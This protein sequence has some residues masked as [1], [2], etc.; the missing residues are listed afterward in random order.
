MVQVMN[1]FSDKPD[2][3]FSDNII[4]HDLS[5]NPKII[6]LNVG[7]EMKKWRYDS[8]T[9][10][11][12]E[13]LPEFALKYSDLLQ[14]RSATATKFLRKA[15]QTI[16]NTDK[17]GKRGEFGELLLHAIIRE[18]FDSEPVISKIYYKSA[19]NDTVKGF[20]AVHVVE[21]NAELELWLGEVKFYKE[22]SKAITDVLDE[23]KKHVSR[24]YLKEEF[25]LITTKIDDKWVHAEKVK[26]L[27]STRT[28]LDEVFKRLSIP[29]LLTYESDSVKKFNEVSDEFKK[30]LKGEL[31]THYNT[32]CNKLSPKKLNIHLFLMPIED[33]LELIKKLHEKLEGFQR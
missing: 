8:F 16:Y 27:L 24:D 1:F 26:K 9:E 17:Y 12:F 22:I 7:Y 11:L 33:K 31:E 2:P 19:T 6:G 25:S 32:F 13:W 5:S 30:S 21:N 14:I 3:Y 10:Y 28:S 4:V 29:V 18:L 15:A 23:L 20:D